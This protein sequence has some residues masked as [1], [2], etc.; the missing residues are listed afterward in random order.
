MAIKVMKNQIFKKPDKPSRSIAAS[1]DGR[2]QRRLNVRTLVSAEDKANLNSSGFC[3]HDTS[4]MTTR[5]PVPAPARRR[6]KQRKNARKVA[7]EAPATK[8]GE[9][10]KAKFKRAAQRLLER[11][12]Y[13][14]LRLSDIVDAAGYNIA[15]FYYYFK[16]KQSIVREVIADIFPHDALVAEYRANRIALGDLHSVILA[17]TRSQIRAFAQH[18][19]LMRSIA[20]FADDEPELAEFVHRRDELWTELIADDILARFAGKGVSRAFALAFAAMLNGAVRTFLTEIYVQ[21]NPGLTAHFQTEEDLADFVA[22]FWWRA[23]FLENPKLDQL[24]HSTEFVALKQLD[25]K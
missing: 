13:R 18:P 3:A 1:L 22:A 8:R 6:A 12:S 20:Q 17:T 19:G 7:P 16:D 5:N 14:E 9:Q 2:R 11:M 15:T 21:K 23:T 4:Q 24:G 25:E 10:A